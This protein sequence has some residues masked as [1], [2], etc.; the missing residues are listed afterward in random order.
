MKLLKKKILALSLASLCLTGTLAAPAEVEAASTAEKLL[1]GAA[2]MLFIS[3][4]YSRMDDNNQLSFLS[5]CQQQTGVYES[6][7]AD[8]R[9]QEI[10]NRIVDTGAVERSYK[11]YV[12]PDEDINAFMSLGGVMC[13]NKG[14]LDTMDDDELA[15]IM[16]HEFSHGEMR[17]S[18]NGVKKR[19]GLMVALNVYLGDRSYGERLLGGI[20]GNYVANAVFTKDQEKEADDWGFQY[21]V[22]AGYNPGAGA[23]AMQVLKDKYGESSP[24]GIKAVL[25]PGN[26]PKTSDRISKNLKWMSAYSGNHV[27]VKDDMIFVNGE[28]AFQAAAMGKYTDK[29]R[30]YL[31][32]GK[33]AKLYHAG[34]VPDAVLTDNVIYCGNTALYTLN[35]EENG[36]AYTAALNK[37]IQKNRGEAVKDNFKIDQ[38]REKIQREK[39]K[40]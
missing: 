27:Q 17:H 40:K 36:K 25:A 15:Y 39:D 12:S 4:Y 9:V 3:Q 32:A 34:H 33:L 22:E 16:A 19:V 7:E 26:H 24:S 10:Y 14:S 28:K 2:A 5:Q 1:Y 13:V 37:G 18:V 35:D 23:A 29:E 20:A 8:N 21:T 11:V 31:T 6:A 38:R 30:T